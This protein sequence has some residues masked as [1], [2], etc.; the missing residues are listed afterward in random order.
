MQFW[1]PSIFGLVLS[2]HEGHLEKRKS[3]SVILFKALLSCVVWTAQRR[4]Y[5]LS[6]VSGLN[7]S[8]C[9][10]TR[11]SALQGRGNFTGDFTVKMD[12]V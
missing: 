5:L 3:H 9:E 6:V 1:H 12:S 7:C 4:K 2:R 10:I 11:L 8:V